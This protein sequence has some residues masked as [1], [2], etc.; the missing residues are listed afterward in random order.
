VD[1]FDKAIDFLKALGYSLVVQ[2][3]KW[4]T[5]FQLRGLEITL[6]EMPYGNFS[7]IEGED[8]A[9]IR[10][11]SAALALDWE[12]RINASY[13]SLFDSLNRRLNLN[14]KDLTFEIFKNIPVTARDL[15]VRPA[16]TPQYL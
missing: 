14:L 7:E 3:E 10:S 16:D 8:T 15:G 4:R 11:T 9:V 12:C 2:Y 13:L 1:D 5:T 6:D